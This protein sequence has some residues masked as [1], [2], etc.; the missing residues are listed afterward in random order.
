MVGGKTFTSDQVNGLTYT[1]EDAVESIGF[2]WFQAQVI[3]TSGLFSV[4]RNVFFPCSPLRFPTDTGKPGKW[5]WSWKSH[6]TWKIGQKL[7]NS[8][9]SHWI[10]PIL[11]QNY[12][13]FLLFFVT[14]KK[15]SSNLESLHFSTF[16]AKCCECKIG[17]KD[18]YGKS[19]NGGG[20]VI[21]KYFVKCLGT[22][23]YNSL[24]PTVPCSG[25]PLSTVRPSQLKLDLW[26]RGDVKIPP[27][28][29]KK[30]KN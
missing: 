25:L 18:G 2:G 28:P 7:W 23:L 9:M 19:R 8:V 21:D 22:L 11:P 5:K 26:V 29:Q 17:K 6:G 12:V 1:V 3:I 30:K 16:S 24:T 20:K 14:T 27:P 10:L 13:K 15:L 4:S